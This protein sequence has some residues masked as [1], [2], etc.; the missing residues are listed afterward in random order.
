MKKV[1]LFAALILLQIPFLQA[2]EKPNAIRVGYGIATYDQIF[3]AFEDVLDNIISIGSY[4]R[5]NESW[6][7]GAFL[8]YHHRLWEKYSIGGTFMWDRADADI[9]V[10]NEF[11]GKSKQDF[12]TLAL[13]VERRHLDKDWIRL[14]S[15]LGVGMMYVN[16]DFTSASSNLKSG[17]DNAMSITFQLNLLGV[18]IGKGLAF[19]AEGGLGYRGIVN[20]GASW[21]F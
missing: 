17:S 10:L 20:F 18:R 16:D 6:K 9:Y 1:I 12:Y 21:E 14:Y 7:G 2:Q 19:F 4:K 8:S 13:E 5:E 3:N 11:A 15:G